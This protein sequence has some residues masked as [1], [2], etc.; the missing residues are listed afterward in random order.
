[1]MAIRKRRVISFDEW[2]P[3]PPTDPV[4]IG[5]DI[6]AEETPGLGLPGERR[7]L[8]C[9]DCDALLQL[10]GS[11]YGLFYGCATYPQCRG[12]HGAH[13]DGRPLGTPANKETR[14]ARKD[15]HDMFDR[16]WKGENPLMS[17]SSAYNWLR[18]G[19][20]VPANTHISNLTQVQCQ[21]LVAL[22]RKKFPGLQ[23]VWERLASDEDLL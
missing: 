22:I 23:N 6:S 18:K 20:K 8:K 21:R 13:P 17:R 7:D 15:A 4:G 10:R 16:L 5:E 11:K 19:L 2:C 14:G 9:P 12:T 3:P 1:M